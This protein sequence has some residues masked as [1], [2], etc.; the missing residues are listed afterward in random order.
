MTEA[1]SR[2]RFALLG[3]LVF[4]A[5]GAVR[6][7]FHEPWRDECGVWLLARN[8]GTLAEL[9]RPL[10]YGGHPYLWPLLVW[11]L[12]RVTADPL[13]M[14]FL[15]LGLATVAAFLL[16]RF[17]PWPRWEALLCA[18][19]YYFAFEYA[20]I[21][22]GYVL[23]TIGLVL[24]AQAWP[25]RRWT[26]GLGLVLL[27]QSTVYGLI[28][29]V[30][31]GLASARGS[32][33]W[34]LG[35]AAPLALGTVAAVAMMRPPPDEG[36]R[37]AWYTHYERYRANA[38]AA[39]SWKALVPVPNGRTPYLWNSNV[40]ERAG[41]RK[42]GVLG[43][44][45][46][47]GAVGV[48]V[49]SR[50]AVVLLV[51][52]SVGV[53]AFEYLKLIGYQRHIGHF[54]L[55]VVLALWVAGRSPDRDWFRRGLFAIHAI[56]GLWLSVADLAKPFTAN[57]AAA[58]WIA[59]HAPAD[60]LLAGHQAHQASGVGLYLGRPVYYPDADRTGTFIVWDNR[61]DV[62]LS[63]SEVFRRAAAR[64]DATGRPVVLILSQE[65]PPEAGFRPVA[66]FPRSLI[67]DER[68]FLYQRE[69]PSAGIDSPSGGP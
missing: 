1:R 26:G 43:L 44:A 11:P 48:V 38:V 12:G 54:Y 69:K 64:G 51:T 22:R 7:W 37:P 59:A 27:T 9:L 39:M 4:A 40:L 42:M 45:L 24:V 13:A 14:Q 66:R 49:R 50:R 57:R 55:A 60:A 16:L 28:L 33:A 17:A 61:R 62:Y 47:A 15:H 46:L 2:I 18:F 63:A 53:F 67:E 52:A 34:L 68:L 20:V 6:V 35:W 65:W 56:A 31:A 21:A 30:A 3:A 41:T 32:R 19:G 25:Q 23:G 10:R 36:Y 58:N 5:W 8:C 29:A